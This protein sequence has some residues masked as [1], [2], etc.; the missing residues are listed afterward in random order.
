MT[1]LFI[2]LVMLFYR[3]P[4][5]NKRD[6][7]TEDEL[8]K[9]NPDGYERHLGQGLTIDLIIRVRKQLRDQLK[10]AENNLSEF[11]VSCLRESEYFKLLKDDYVRNLG[12]KNNF[13]PYD[14]GRALRS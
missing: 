14:I 13:S 8:Y 10:W 7:N 9:A 1:W 6:W 12:E 3:P 2:L 5:L 11:G 4:P